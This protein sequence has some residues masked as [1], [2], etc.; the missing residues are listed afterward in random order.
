MDKVRTI[1]EGKIIDK[2]KTRILDL[3][4]FPRYVVEYLI[5]N[6]CKDETFQEDLAKVKA[7]LLSEYATP[8]EADRLKHRIKQSRRSTII[9]KCEVHLSPEEDKY[10]AAIP[11]IGEYHIHIPEHFLEQYPRLL[12]GMWGVIEIGYD[13]TQIWHGKI[14]PFEIRDFTP[15]QVAKISIDEFI[16]ARKS[17]TTQEW[18]DFLVTTIGLNPEAFSYKQ[19]LYLIL[20]LVPLV[21]KFTNLIE[22]GPRE[23][24]KS[25]MFKNLSYYV[26]MLS[27]GKATRASLF[28][29]LGTGKPGI[30]S[31]FDGVVFDEIAHT[32]F[33]D[34]QTT[35]S[36][37]K[38]YMEYG[39]FQL[40]KHSVIGEASLVM[41][42][43][44][45]VLGDQ[46]HE[47]Y[48]H[49]FEPLPED[50]QD[51]ALLHRIQGYIPGWDF[52][53][54]ESDLYASGPGLVM[55]YFAEI[56]HAL[57]SIDPV[58]DLNQRYLLHNAT[59]RDDKAIFKLLRGLLKLLHPDGAVT[60]DELFRYLEV[61][62]E[63][64]QRVLDQLHI[65]APG[66]F[67]QRNLSFEIGGRF[68]K[69]ELRER[70]R[71]VKISIPL[72]PEI[73]KVVGLAVTPKGLGMIQLFEV[74]ATKGSGRLIPLGNMGGVMKESLKT[75][76]EYISHHRKRFDIDAE[77]K[78]GYDLSV[79]ALQMAIPK[80]GPSSGLAFV[81]G[82]ISA[83]S[84]R[85]VR[86][87]TA[88]T[89]EITLH[90][91]VLG[92]GGVSQKIFAAQ[93]AGAARVLVPKENQLE[94]E[95][96]LEQL[97]KPID[98]IYVSKVDEAL[99]EALIDG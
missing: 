97:K 67:S 18:L 13:P 63:L 55:D 56:L 46:P 89:G 51:I 26:Y 2:S 61:V 40:G 10:W 14:R 32:E 49:L 54:L 93:K 92:V 82:I 84:K 4:E 28:V 96:A 99:R 91:E 87:D 94:A 72:S 86:N 81:L 70:L 37:F 77:F 76:Y 57:R 29:H 95:K 74:L 30:V 69:P 34:P 1:F 7:K 43:N 85:P 73:G 80:E 58:P 75:A 42:G 3:Q 23:T 20:R 64:R 15:F 50:L 38:D 9:A 66:E 16:K 88:V 12:G 79:L 78:E 41:I 35:I 83:L 22:L 19:K 60:D 59:T 65:M 31:Q 5:D 47:K 33:T 6:F 68:G 44:L 21:E 8:R 25:Y 98:L 27:G 11:A 71:E 90:G 48:G 45:D 53:K 17:F 36:I 39:S 24:G 62:A 52:P